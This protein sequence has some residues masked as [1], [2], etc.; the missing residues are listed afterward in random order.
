MEA[1]DQWSS[2]LVQNTISFSK[3]RSRS[4]FVRGFT[5]HSLLEIVGNRDRFSSLSGKM[6]EGSES[7][8]VTVL[9]FAQWL[10]EMRSRTNSNIQQV[11]AEMGIIRNGITTNNTDLVEFKRNCANIQQQQQSQLADLRDKL[12]DAFNEIAGMKKA[13]AQSDQE[14][15]ADYQSLA[16]QL[17]FKHVELETLK[18]AYAQTH[19]QLQQQ[20]IQL[21]TDLNEVRLARDETHRMATSSH[22]GLMTKTS[23][24]DMA[25]QHATNELKRIRVD[26]DQAIANLADNMNKWNDT[27]RDLSREFHEFQKLMTT[28]QQKLQTSIDNM[29]NGTVRPDSV[30]E[31]VPPGSTVQSRPQPGM[32]S[33]SRMQ[34]TINMMGARPVTMMSGM[35]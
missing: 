4:D 12:Q 34:P 32:M 11:L 26:H 9:A 18:K 17:N 31:Q 33:M 21:Q 6:E 13:K 22:E 5:L 24:L 14:I 8:D 25:T 2:K 1:V 7:V 29:Q 15:A 3:T 19:Q 27:I 20:I 30:R 10:S 35:H 16:E 23:D 28:N